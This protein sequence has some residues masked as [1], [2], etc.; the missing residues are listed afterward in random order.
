MVRAVVTTASRA[1]IKLEISIIID[2][3]VKINRTRVLVVIQN[4]TKND[5]YAVMK[6]IIISIAIKNG[7]MYSREL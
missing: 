5:N 1:L 3:I 7:V 2:T 6:L 4:S